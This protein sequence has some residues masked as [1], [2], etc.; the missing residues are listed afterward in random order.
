[1]KY[2][3]YDISDCSHLEYNRKKI[4]LHQGDQNNEKDLENFIEKFQLANTID[5]IIDD[6]SHIGEHIL[7]S[8]KTLFKYLNCGGVYFIEGLHAG[9]ANREETIQKIEIF[10]QENFEFNFEINK[11]IYKLLIIKKK[12]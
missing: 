1:M 12:C 3:G 5:F 2:F 10:L 6:G 8:F 11:D 4:Q 7:T 9:Q